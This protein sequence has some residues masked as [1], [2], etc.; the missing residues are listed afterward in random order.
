MLRPIGMMGIGACIVFVL[1]ACGLLAPEEGPA[2]FTAV[3]PAAPTTTPPP[4]VTPTKTLPPPTSTPVPSPPAPTATAAPKI[5]RGGILRG[6]QQRAYTSL[7]SSI[8]PSRPQWALGAL[9]DCLLDLE[10]GGPARPRWEMTPGLAVSWRQTDATI[11]DLQIRSGV[12]FHDGSMLTAEDV[13]FSLD[14]L[15]NHP[16]SQARDS[17]SAQE[18]VEILDPQTVRVTLK[19]PQAGY[20]PSLSCLS[21]PAGILPKSVVERLGDAEFGR[22]P[23]GTGPFILADYAPEDR[24]TVNKFSSYWDKGDDGQPLPYLDGASFR[25]VDETAMM[26]VELRAGTLDIVDAVNQRDVLGIKASQDIVYDESPGERTFRFAHGF[27]PSAGPFAQ[28][29]RLRQAA[30]HAV[31]REG[32]NRLFAFG[33]GRPAYHPFWSPG[34]L[35]YDESLP[36]YEFN[37]EKA[38][39]LVREAGYATGLEITLTGIAREP[40]RRIAE[41]VKAMWDT[42]GLRTRVELSER[43]AFRARMADGSF[44]AGFWGTRSSLDPDLQRRYFHSQG[45][46]NW[47]GWSDE[48]M[49]ACLDEGAAESDGQKRAEVYKRCQR[50]IYE[51]AFLG[52]GYS[53]AS[54]VAMRKAVRGI[55]WEWGAVSLNRAWLER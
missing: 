36:R 51:G 32:L 24:V 27:N 46:A 37:P 13:K 19:A 47:N 9:Y 21:A 4:P 33:A 14:R 23:I 52:A 15:A 26:L 28:D 18:D 1:A 54:A 38:R 10:Y 55:R 45:L 17:L 35:G 50:I 5:K 39:Q 43:P 25:V 29:R 49:D 42:V 22:R 12:R 48:K 41:A 16:R 44:D 7:D 3:V 40:D 8:A 6:A 20:L 11:I 53:E 2:T 34:M 30:E 31:D